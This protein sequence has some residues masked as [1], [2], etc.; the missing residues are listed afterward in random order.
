MGGDGDRH[1]GICV[2]LDNRHTCDFF[3]Y[4]YLK[5][6][7]VQWFVDRGLHISTSEVRTCTADVRS[8]HGGDGCG[9]IKVACTTAKEPVQSSRR[10]GT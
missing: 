7:I 5:I 9:T 10:C 1:V 2:S 3:I 4:R 6:Y 8:G